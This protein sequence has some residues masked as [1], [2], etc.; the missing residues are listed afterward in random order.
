M[1]MQVANIQRFCMHDGDGIRTT[2]FLKGCPLNCV[3]CHNPETNKSDCEILFYPGRC[4]GC[5]ECLVCLNDAHEFS[6]SHFYN[7]QKCEKCGECVALCPTGALEKVGEQI[8]VD[9]VFNLVQKDCAFYGENGGVTVSG[10]EPFLQADEVTKLFKKCKQH[11][12]TTAVETCGYF[13]GDLLKEIIPVC[14]MFLWDIKDTNPARHKKYTGVDNKI[15]LENA[16]YLKQSG[17]P[18]AFRTPLIPNI[19]DT[20]ENLSAIERIVKGSAWEKLDYNPLAGAKYA[21]VG[22][23]F[24]L[25]NEFK[26]ED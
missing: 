11:G 20:E 19:T 3:W 8:S 22:R 18:H 5:K 26:K 23:K 9:E 17:I 12:I 7:R 10:G 2:V 4:I 15:I 24:T 21:S 25:C 6:E 14:D 1:L 16:K 13:N